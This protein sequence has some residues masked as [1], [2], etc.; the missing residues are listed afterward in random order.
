MEA[1]RRL[2]APPP[3]IGCDGEL[4]RWNSD[5]SALT[6]EN[7][8]DILRCSEKVTPVNCTTWTD[9]KHNLYLNDLE[10]S[11]VKQL[12]QSKGLFAQCSEQEQIDMNRSKK[13]LMKVHNATEQF[14]VLRNG[15]WQKFKYER[16][17]PLSTTSADSRNPLKSPAT[18]P[19]RRKGSHCLQPSPNMLESLKL[20]S[21]EKP[22][23]VIISHGLATFAHKF[24]SNNPHQGDL[25]D[26]EREGTGQNFLDNENQNRSNVESPAKKPRTALED[27]SSLDQIVPSKK[28]STDYPDFESFDYP[29]T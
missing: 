16:N 14:T 7:C 20:L 18:Y 10:V 4:A 8:K 21:T 17:G 6:A 27:S 15:C 25:F 1:N 2:E 3:R 26:L 28:F 13:R 9:E 22:E 23:K 5:A 29:P 12:R 24:S 19:F 11:F